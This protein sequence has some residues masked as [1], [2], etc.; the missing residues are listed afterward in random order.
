MG[1]AW[2]RARTVERIR[3]SLT[4]FHAIGPIRWEASGCGSASGGHERSRD[5]VGQAA[6]PATL[7][8]PC[9][10]RGHCRGRPSPDQRPSPPRTRTPRRP[11]PG[12]GPDRARARPRPGPH[13][14]SPPRGNQPDTG[15]ARRS[16]PTR[17]SRSP[18]LARSR[19]RRRRPPCHRPSQASG[20]SRPPPRSPTTSTPRSSPPPRRYSPS[21]AARRG[22][23]APTD[24]P[25]PRRTR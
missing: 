1:Q 4:S 24:P 23:G 14:R 2:V 25:W 3:P 9:G 15:H 16:H 8:A 18:S 5:Q 20:S 11:P 22:C 19:C 13:L 6:A 17:P 12:P 21:R 7:G 10:R